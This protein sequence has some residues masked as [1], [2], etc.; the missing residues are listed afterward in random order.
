MNS[1]YRVRQFFFSVFTLCEPLMLPEAISGE[2]SLNMI[3]DMLLVSEKKRVLLVTTPGTVKR[4]TLNPFISKLKEKDI[5]VTV[6]SEV[7][8][9]P[10]VE[11]VEACKE[12]F[13]KGACE[14]I[15]AVGGGSVMDC[16]KVAAARAVCPKKSVRSMKGMLKVGKKIP[17]FYAVPT[18]AGTGSET[19]AAAVIT[20]TI[21]GLHYKYPITDLHLI[22]KYAVLDPTLTTGLPKGI[23]AATG[24]DALTHA[25]EAYTNCFAS[26]FVKKK[27][28]DAVKLIFENLE[29]TYND[30]SNLEARE[31]MLVG[32]F[33]AG[34]AFTVN[35]VGYVHAVAHAIGALYGV[36][37]GEANA[38][39]LP[40][41]L[42]MFGSSVYGKLA[43][44]ADA[45]GIIGESDEAKA[46]AFIKAIRKMNNNMGLPE[47]FEALKREDFDIIID[48]AM[49]E[50]VPTYPTPVIW[51]R[52][53]FRSL[54]LK[55]VV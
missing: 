9:D 26:A 16:A 3:A 47:G 29:K 8:P 25:V 45:V 24:M 35:F 46:K 44:L 48:R 5:S 38:V 43:K 32:S 42:E 22:P 4:G 49:S 1:L 31:N 52:E 18:T 27:A 36:P 19:T 28:V 21:D 55:L 12:V 30:G 15:V 7:V 37:H 14:A 41:V 50:G 2:N 11:C 34:E 53:D 54:L 6:F 17:D 33:Y 13:V 39:I 51:K 23:T 40:Y 10:T 20:D